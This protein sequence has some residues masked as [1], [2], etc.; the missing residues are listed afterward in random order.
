MHRPGLSIVIG[1]SCIKNIYPRYGSDEA[2]L[3]GLK[4]IFVAN[5]LM[6]ASNTEDA[7]ICV[8]PGSFSLIMTT[9]KNQ[10]FETARR[11]DLISEIN[12]TQL[13][14]TK[15]FVHANY[16]LAGSEERSFASACS[17][18]DSEK[19][20]FNG[21]LKRTRSGFKYGMRSR[22]SK[23]SE[24]KCYTCPL[25]ALSMFDNKM[26]VTI[27]NKVTKYVSLRKP[28]ENSI[29]TFMTVIFNLSVL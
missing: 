7:F 27:Q 16:S 17:L 24:N 1:L 10:Y 5:S 19:G 23:R 29:I 25:Q 2:S 11:I 22:A 18:N 21:E 9:N 15:S 12:G 3:C 4:K 8:S 14:I 28:I 6:T 26:H 20:L 13:Q